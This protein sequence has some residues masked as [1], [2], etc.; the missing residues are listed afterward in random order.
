MRDRHHDLPVLHPDSGD[1]D[2]RARDSR[3][4]NKLEQL[5]PEFP[6]YERCRPAAVA[7]R[8]SS[9]PPP[10]RATCWQRLRSD[11]DRPTPFALRPF[12]HSAQAKPPTRR[13]R[14]SQNV[15]SCSRGQAGN[16]FIGVNH[17]VALPQRRESLW[18]ERMRRPLFLDGRA[19]FSVQA[20]GRSQLAART[21]CNLR[22]MRTGVF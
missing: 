4:R 18:R 22:A 11:R 8:T 15:L 3:S 20:P 2:A 7:P 1:A 10:R 17:G 12:P 14:G 5:R 9:R 21:R 6:N 13:N 16:A 19:V